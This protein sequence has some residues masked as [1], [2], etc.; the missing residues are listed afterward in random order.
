MPRCRDELQTREGE[1]GPRCPGSSD[2]RDSKISGSMA[3]PPNPLPAAEALPT[4]AAGSSCAQLV[5][6]GGA[7][8]LRSLGRGG[9]GAGGSRP[10]GGAAGPGGGEERRPRPAGS[11]EGGHS[12]SRL[13]FVE[14][15]LCHFTRPRA[16]SPRGRHPAPPRNKLSLKA[17]RG[18]LQEGGESGGKPTQGSARAGWAGAEER[19]WGGQRATLSWDPRR[20][21]S[22]SVSS[23]F[24]RQSP[25]QESEMGYQ[26]KQGRCASRCQNHCTKERRMFPNFIQNENTRN[27]KRIPVLKTEP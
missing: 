18:D 16:T 22:A 1:E 20:Q 27:A 6:G 21:I 2:A 24:R 11:W 9:Q 14:R 26:L 4:A 8:A 13:A 17:R 5:P 23:E 15:T 3:A 19:S 25:P 12:G 7:G 10:R